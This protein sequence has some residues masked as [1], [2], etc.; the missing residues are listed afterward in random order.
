MGALQLLQ[1]HYTS[2]QILTLKEMNVHE[3]KHA[4]SL[5]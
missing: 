1:K 5:F 4:A 2:L 3:E